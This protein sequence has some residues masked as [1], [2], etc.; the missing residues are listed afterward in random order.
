MWVINMLLEKIES[1]RY[2]LYELMVTNNTDL[3]LHV[4][5]ELD[6]LIVEYYNECNQNEKYDYCS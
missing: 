2:L 5:E 4:S 6:E 3:I 1:L